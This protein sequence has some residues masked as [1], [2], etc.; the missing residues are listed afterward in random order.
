MGVLG[1]SEAPTN[2]GPD[3]GLGQAG[4]HPAPAWADVP[5]NDYMPTP[6]AADEA[7]QREG[8]AQGGSP[9]AAPQKLG[10][11]PVF[12][13]AHWP[14][15]EYQA[16][17]GVLAEGL[18]RHGGDVA[19]LAQEW[20]R[21]PDDLQQRM[22]RFNVSAKDFA[23]PPPPI[24]KP[25]AGAGRVA[26][27]SANA[28]VA[29]NFSKP[30]PPAPKPNENASA[31]KGQGVRPL[32]SAANDQVTRRAPVPVSPNAP[33]IKLPPPLPRITAPNPPKGS[34]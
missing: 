20:G 6:S 17:R 19:A 1:A 32:P 26:G 22:D 28:Q 21:D 23:K 30:P 34:P 3:R 8:S 13:K 27:P 5:M 11:Q 16:R 2:S 4:T 25:S 9:Q 15:E 29:H 18:A 33:T 10:G 7:T 24:L 31:A 14:K 12:D